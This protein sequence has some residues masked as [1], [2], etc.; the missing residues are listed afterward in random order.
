MTLAGACMRLCAL[1]SA[2][3]RKSV[4]SAVVHEL[5]EGDFALSVTSEISSRAPGQKTYII[6]FGP[7]PIQIY[8]NGNTLHKIFHDVVGE[9][10]TFVC[11]MQ[12]IAFVCEQTF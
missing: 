12:A 10:Q 11:E 7:L 3:T 2:V 4:P 1:A 8:Y 6:I 5:S 9:I